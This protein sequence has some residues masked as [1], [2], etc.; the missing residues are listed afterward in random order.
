M[1]VK[2]VL[3]KEKKE[4]QFYKSCLMFNFI[5]LK[6]INRIKEIIIFFKY[7]IL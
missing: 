6:F 5:E 1:V 3:Q 2:F 4:N 7:I